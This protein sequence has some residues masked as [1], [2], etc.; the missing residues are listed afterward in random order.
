MIQYLEK[1]GTRICNQVYVYSKKWKQPINVS[2]TVAQLFHTQVKRPVVNV[3]MNGEK[4]ELVKES[5]YLGF[6]WTD[7]LS[8][9]PTV[10]KCIGNIHRSLGKLRWLKTGRSMSSKLLRQYF[11]GY[12]F[13]HFAWIFPFFPL[14]AQTQQQILQQKF[15]VGLRL[16]IVVRLCLHRT[17]IVSLQSTP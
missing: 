17:F 2:K 9:K 14:L 7:R 10:E 1:E 4:I 5:K 8:L 16:C 6:T 12:T 15:L 13:P 3:T 11:F